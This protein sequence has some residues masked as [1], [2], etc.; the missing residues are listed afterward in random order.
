MG[1]QIDK[2]APKMITR[3]FWKNDFFTL[4]H[5]V[6]PTVSATSGPKWTI[7]LILGYPL[8]ADQVSSK[9]KLTPVQGYFMKFWM[10]DPCALKI[11]ISVANLDKNSRNL[12]STPTSML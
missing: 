5:A 9:S 8:S 7:L 12:D 2:S 4:W 10:F 11:G 3:N 6:L 1:Y